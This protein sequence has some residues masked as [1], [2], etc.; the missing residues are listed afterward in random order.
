MEKIIEK[1][2]A[3]SQIDLLPSMPEKEIL[4]QV[5]KDVEDVNAQS[6]GSVRGLAPGA[7]LEAHPAAEEYPV[8]SYE[9]YRVLENSIRE[10]GLQ[11]PIK[12]SQGK[13]I[14]GRHRYRACIKLEIPIH[15][16]E[17]NLSEEE[18]CGYVYSSN[19]RRSLST[20]QWALKALKELPEYEDR[21]NERKLSCL[22][23]NTVAELI[24][25]RKESGRVIELLAKAYPVNPKYILYAKRIQESKPELLE[26]VF[27]G[28]MGII[29]AHKEVK[30]LTVPVEK[31]VYLSIEQ[32]FQIALDKLPEEDN[33]FLHEL[34]EQTNGKTKKILL[35]RTR[36]ESL[37]ILNDKINKIIVGVK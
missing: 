21:A 36:R 20:G 5:K 35:N 15:A 7:M 31:K 18:I 23:Q 10:D 34:A 3:Q 27:S 30:I 24:P 8:L 4:I 26:K 17:L 13:I 19:I 14:D 2:T 22:A 37:E 32:A 25:Q 33:D 6:K 28:E 11:E 12:L 16:E 1:N 9:E 29:D